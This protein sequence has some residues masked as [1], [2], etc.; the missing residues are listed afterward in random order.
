M[1]VRGAHGW[2]HS[3]H[4]PQKRTIIAESPRE[5]RELRA[6]GIHTSGAEEGQNSMGAQITIQAQM[7]RRGVVLLSVCAALCPARALL[8][9]PQRPVSRLSTRLQADELDEHSVELSRPDIDWDGELSAIMK[10][11][12]DHVARPRGKN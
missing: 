12:Q 11:E 2:E 6:R 4:V 7:A 3:T 5:G 9:G 10:G 1:R 8:N